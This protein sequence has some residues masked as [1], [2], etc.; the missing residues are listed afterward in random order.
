MK[1]KLIATSAVVCALVLTAVASALAGSSAKHSGSARAR[2]STQASASAPGPMGAGGPGGPG[3]G[4]GGPHDAVHSVS[5]VLNKAGTAYVTET[6]DSGTLETVDAGAST[7]TIKEGTKTV[8]Y[9][10]PTLTIPGGATVTLDGRTSSLGALAAG[11][12]VTV[13]SSTEGTRVFAT[14]SS[15]KPE[16]GA[17]HGGPPPSASASSPAAASASGEPGGAA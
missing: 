12:Q 4:F 7:L 8:T 14:D 6:S 5:V 10:T 17:S 15:F 3:G 13:T 2:H 11:D 1:K 16:A 9:G